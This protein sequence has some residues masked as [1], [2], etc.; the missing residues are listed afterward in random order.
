MRRL[1]LL[2]VIISIVGCKKE[3]LPLRLKFTTEERE[4]FI[5]QMGQQFKFKNSNGDSLVYTVTNVEHRYDTPEYTDT[6]YSKLASLR[7]TYLAKLESD[8]DFI[9]FYFYKES[10]FGGEPN[11]MKQT[12][13]WHSMKNQFVELSAIKNGTPFSSRTVNG[14]TYNKVTEAIPPWHDVYSFT[15]FDF[16]YYDQ[17]SGFIEITDLKGDTWKR[18]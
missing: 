12:I 17:K 15:K 5:Y 4:W 9:I 7:E 18:Q 2:I 11:K 16:A 13:A 8:S 10:I 1:Y 3:D 14:L 6:S